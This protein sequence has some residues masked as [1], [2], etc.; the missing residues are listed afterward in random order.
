MDVMGLFLMQVGSFTAAF[1][2]GGLSD[3]INPGRTTIV[4]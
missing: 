3:N 4:P 2:S 1:T